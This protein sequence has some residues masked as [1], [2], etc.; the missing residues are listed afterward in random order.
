MKI[1]LNNTSTRE[2]AESLLHG[3]E[4][5]SLATGRVLT[6]LVVARASDDLDSVLLTVRE[7]TREHP[8]RVLVLVCGDPAAATSI[9]AEV[10][11][12]AEAGASEMVVMHLAGELVGHPASVVTPLLLPDTPIV[13]WWPTAAP[14]TPADSPLGVIAQRRITDASREDPG[15]ALLRLNG[16]YAAGDSDMMWSRITMWRGNVAAAL[17]HNPGAAIRSVRII[18]PADDPSVDLAAGWLASCL[19]VDVERRF[20]TG[21]CPI[22][23]NVPITELVIE[24]DDGAVTVSVIDERTVRVS[25]P[26]LPDSHVAMTARTDAEC[27]AEELRHLDPDTAYARAL[28]GLEHVITP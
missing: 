9:D 5:F 17:D 16:G 4:L 11:L 15:S 6:L 27:L 24:R 19:R 12:T 3:Q 8:A 22:V 1:T 2:I 14:T 28:A 7:A 23:R 26:G 18:G 25:S 13:A 20:T 21:R 10:V